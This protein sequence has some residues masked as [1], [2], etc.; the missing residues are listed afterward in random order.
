[1]FGYSYPTHENI[2][3]VRFIGNK[4]SGKMG[5]EIALSVENVQK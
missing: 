1:M 5:L 4:S 2:D 3:P